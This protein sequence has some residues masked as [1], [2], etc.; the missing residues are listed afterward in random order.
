MD[1]VTET[2]KTEQRVNHLPGPWTV[3]QADPADPLWG[4]YATVRGFNIRVAD[5]YD[6]ADASVIAAAPDLLAALKTTAGN[7]RS[8]GPAGALP[9]SCSVWLRVVD[10][11]IAKAEGRTSDNAAELERQKREGVGV[12]NPKFGAEGRDV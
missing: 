8:L 11:A 7:I 5:V 10:A 1:S 2:Q 6:G 3:E 4:V 12:F 9:D